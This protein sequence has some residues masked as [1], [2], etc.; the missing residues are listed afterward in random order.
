MIANARHML[1]QGIFLI[2]D[3]SKQCLERVSGIE[4]PYWT[5]ILIQDRNIFQMSLF[6]RPDVTQ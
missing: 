1:S 4:H 6:E 2:F 5:L 3:L